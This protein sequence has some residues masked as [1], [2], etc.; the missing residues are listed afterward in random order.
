MRKRL[1]KKKV[2]QAAKWNHNQPLLY[3]PAN[4]TL[5]ISGEPHHVDSA[6]KIWSINKDGTIKGRDV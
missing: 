4:D 3:D 6:T 2:A 1:R 5:W